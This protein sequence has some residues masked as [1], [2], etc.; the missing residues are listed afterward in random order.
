MAI[1][2]TKFDRGVEGATNIVDSGTEGT[3]VASGTTAQRG[4]TQGQLR[5]NTTTNLAEYYDG[6][7]FKAI[8]SSPEI[9][10]ISPT[11]IDESDLTA[12]QTIVITGSNF[13]TGATVKIIG[14]DGTEITPTS[15]TRNSATQITITTPTSGITASNEPYGIKVLNASGLSKTVSTLLNINDKPVFS[16][17]AGSLGTLLDGARAGSNLTQVTGTDEE[18][19]AITFAVTSG[20]IPAGL[21]FNSN[22]TF[23]GTANAVNSLTTSTFTVTAT[24]GGQTA[25]RQ[26]TASVSPPPIIEYLVVAGGGGGGDAEN[27]H[28]GRAGGA[29]GAGGLRNSYASENTGGGASGE[30]AFTASSGT[31]YTITVGQGG[32]GRAGDTH[33]SG[34]NGGASSISGSGLTTISTVGGGGGGYGQY[35]NGATG[36]SGGSGGGGGCAFQGSAGGG[37][38]GTSGQ[39]YDGGS[40]TATSRNAG[41]GGG[42]A[43]QVGEAV[44]V[45]GTYYAGDGGNGLQSSITGSAIYY[46]GGGGG[47]SDNSGDVAGL[48]G[49]GGGGRGYDYNNDA[50][51]GTANTGGGGGGGADN[52]SKPSKA[53]GSGVVILRLPTSQYTGTTTGSPTV[54]QSGTDT[55]I[56][57]T[58]DGSYTA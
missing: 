13:G 6:T 55:I 25:T 53:G 31:Q 4:S 28:Y 40:A 33:T 26:Y 58:G 57:F 44:G 7:A 56:K 12:N 29:G 32:T 17:A 8:D 37:G 47:A 27:S 54:S 18:S 41:G 52:A 35:N 46:A 2:K 36:N 11:S 3:R 49:Q 1:I 50:V 38:S 14:N 16:V 10:S 43:A 15:T 45:D 24:S 23:S 5:F 39:G 21:T 34:G 30:S 22:G 48:G 20:S 42:G 19:D 9:N 51:T